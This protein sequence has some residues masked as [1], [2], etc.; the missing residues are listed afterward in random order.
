MK[1]NFSKNISKKAFISILV[2]LLFS[3]SFWFWQI[4]ISTLI[5]WANSVD[6]K[7]SDKESFEAVINSFCKA[8][9]S[10]EEAKPSESIFLYYICNHVKQTDN[11]EEW[12]K[13][14]PST[15]YIK[16]TKDNDGNEV[17]RLTKWLPDF[18]EKTE[19]YIKNIFDKIIWSYITIYQAAIFWHVN[20]K[21]KTNFTEY[22]SEKYFTYWDGFINI[23]A[24]DK[25]YKYPKTCK[26]LKDYI[27]WARNLVNSNENILNDENI[28]KNKKSDIIKSWLYWWNMEKFIDLVYNELIFYSLFVDYYSYLLQTKS[29]FKNWN[30]QNFDIKINKNQERVIKLYNDIDASN[31]AIEISIKILKEI[32]YSF[33]IHIWF[34]MYSEDIY[35]FNW[36]FIKI[37]K[38]LDILQHTFRNVQKKE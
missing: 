23:C 12:I 26:K 34:L 1:K 2:I 20:E 30:E 5:E 33:P 17:N 3:H 28:Y 36:N 35:T 16:F 4:Q 13:E 18:Y 25:D 10:L 14:N 7:N 38:P 32:Q 9:F 19:D 8:M 31:K 37:L 27:H 15:S 24:T 21:E 11:F 29:Y 22:F 6:T